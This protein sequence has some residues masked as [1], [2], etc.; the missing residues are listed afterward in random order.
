MNN[1]QTTLRELTWEIAAQDLRAQTVQPSREAAVSEEFNTRMCQM[2]RQTDEKRR[3][4]DWKPA[5]RA[6]AAVLIVCLLVGGLSALGSVRLRARAERV[7]GTSYLEKARYVVATGGALAQYRLTGLPTGYE[8]TQE[9]SSPVLYSVLYTAPDGSRIAFAACSKG[10]ISVN[11]ERDCESVT[12]NGVSCDLYRN[13]ATSGGSLL[14]EE[15]G[16][17]FLLDCDAEIDLLPDL[18]QKIQKN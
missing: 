14:W 6:V 8:K 12:V 11:N 4:R 13:T 1:V 10:V 15:D 7:V 16:V 2:L 18:A 3:H 9:Y 17:I 5:M